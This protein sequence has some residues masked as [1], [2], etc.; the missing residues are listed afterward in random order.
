LVAKAFDELQMTYL[1]LNVYEWNTAA[2]RCYEKVGFKLNANEIKYSEFDGKKWKA[3][4][5]T[6]DHSTWKL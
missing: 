3:L 5:M 6:I 1:E 4:N 2:I